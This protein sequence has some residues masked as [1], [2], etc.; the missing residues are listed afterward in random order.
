MNPPLPFIRSVKSPWA[1]SHLQV[2]N[3]IQRYVDQL[4][5]RQQGVVKCLYKLSTPS[6]VAVW[7][8]KQKNISALGLTNQPKI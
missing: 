5:L 4:H 8:Y 3:K 7:V 6:L 2:T 1:H